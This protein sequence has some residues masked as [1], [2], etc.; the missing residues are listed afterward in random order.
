MNADHYAAAVR[1][2][3]WIRG[4]RVESRLTYGEAR[5]DGAAITASDRRP[6]SLLHACD[7]EIA[8][9]RA[10]AREIDGRVRMVV[11]ATS[12]EGVSS[13]LSV[14]IGGV[15][16]VTKPQL[17][18]DDVSR[19]RAH[20]GSPPPAAGRG[21]PRPYIW[22]NGTAA[23]L[24]HE[25][26]GHAIEHG[27][28]PMALPSWLE[29]DIEFA[30]RRETFRDVPMQR[31]NSVVLTQTNAP[32]ATPR[33]AIDIEYITGG[34]YDPLTDVVTI[35]IAVP[36]MTVRVARAQIA[37]SFLGATGDPIRYPGVICSRE[38]QELFVESY[39]P[40]LVTRS[41]S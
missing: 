25:A 8:R 31:M 13:T 35:H 19:L 24:L 29:V 40:V 33:D 2:E 11:R 34:T 4:R 21:G 20:V 23:V 39:A 37:E 41:F 1:D 9:V 22:R 5:H 27:K 32:F 14:A 15:S 17:A 7:E 38:G 18:L 28:V 10:I 6:V 12:D 26:E 30:M 16:I 36:R 3:I